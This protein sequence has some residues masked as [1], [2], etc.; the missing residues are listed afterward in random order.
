[1]RGIGNLKLYL[2]VTQDEYQLPIV[3]AS[4]VPELARKTGW[5]VQRIWAYLNHVKHGNIKKPKFIQGV[6]DD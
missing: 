5:S 3:V 1:M 4:S 2:E 6:L